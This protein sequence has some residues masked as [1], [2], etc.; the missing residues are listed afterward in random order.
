M[1][2]GYFDDKNREYVVDKPDTPMSW[3]N[4]LGTSEY[5]SL[6]SNNAAGYSFYK[7]PRLG[8]LMR[9]RFNSI[10]MER[11]GKYVYIRDDS[12]GDFWSASWQPVGKPLGE[13]HTECRHGM[14]YTRFI[15]EYKGIKSN[16]R[17]FVPVD[18]PI[19]FWEIE[20]ENT[21]AQTRNLSLFSYAEY[22]LWNNDNDLSNFQ[23][24][25][26]VARLGYVQDII[27]YS[28]VLWPFYEPKGFMASTLPV[29]SFDTDRE[30]FIGNYHSET[31]PAAVMN[32]KCSGSIACGGNPCAALQN[33]ITLAPGEKKRALFIVGIGDAKTE[34]VK[35][36]ELYQ[37]PMKVEEEFLKVQAYWNDKLG[38]FRINT[39]SDIVNTMGNIW[40]QYQ[41]NT[42]F[43]WSRS[44]SF[45]EAGGR[46]G[47]G[48][49]DS[50]QDTL[51]VVHSR[52]SEVKNKIIDLLKAQLSEGYAMHGVQPLTLKQGEHNIPKPQHI[53]SDDHL[54]LHLSIPAYI[55]E[56]GDDSILWEV[57]PYADKGEATVYDHLKQALEFSWQKRGDHGILLGLAADWNDCINLKGKG[58]STWSSL[59]YYR[60][61]TEF[62]KIAQL[63]GDDA[64]A[65]KYEGYAEAI[66]KSLDAYTWEGDRFARGYLDS[67]RKL[68]SKES[69][70]SKIFLNAQTWAVVSG[71]YR[72]EKGLAAMDSVK[73]YM[74]TEH[75]SVL[76]YP[77]YEKHDAEIGAITSF[78]K[79]LKENSAIFCHANTW[80]IVAEGML[81][82]GDRAFEYYLS[83][84]PAA[85]NENA[86]LYTMEPYVYCQFITG[87]EHPYHFGRA[88]NSWLTG[89]ASWA[90]VALS[91]YILGVRADYDGLVIDPSIPSEWDGFEVYREYRGKGFSIKIE[92]PDHICHG[93]SEILLNGETI[94]GNKIPLEKM[95]PQNTVL[96]K[97]KAIG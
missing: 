18:K 5:A 31:N 42:T 22:C 45:N 69:E 91:Q 36:R 19:E 9:M 39:P 30:V 72:D 95:Q 89:T 35:Y 62:I 52:P 49:R 26:Y 21:S 66:K 4:Y 77:A 32:G 51:G 34:G 88:R 84:L 10:P 48:F 12:D 87:K 97:I 57:V 54:W 74:F 38:K 25:L 29:E 61:L 85:K 53:Y 75:G 83:F 82:R 33:K 6:I 44:A 40:N 14:G 76:N 81:G 86:D 23:Y 67:G 46:D 73:Q 43:N 65:R 94:Q 60:A 50:N 71:A 37:D 47:L 78:P 7:S 11:P 64:D 27:D 20:L 93:V 63:F 80:A 55:K 2:Y 59:L 28:I 17:V 3:I 15:S 8:R 79:G 41:C 58:E 56:T 92:N 24:C 1:R 70:Q 90:F 13:Y 68:G 16:Y 96:V